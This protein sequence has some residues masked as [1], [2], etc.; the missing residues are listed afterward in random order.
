MKYFLIL[1]LASTCCL[2]GDEGAKIAINNRILTN[3]NG[4]PITLMDVTK[5]MDM[6]L[7]ARYADKFSELPFRLS[8]YRE[9][10]RSFLAEMIDH[11]LLLES[12]EELK[13]PV[14]NGDVR[15]ELETSFGPNILTN[16]EKAGL[17]FEEAFEMVKT[18]IITR[19]MLLWQVTSRIHAQITP[20]E[21]VQE[22]ENYSKAMKGRKLFSYQ[23]LSF[24]SPDA[25]IALE[26]ANAAKVLLD[27]KKLAP[28]DLKQ[29]M[30]Q[31]LQESAVTC[32]VSDLITQKK[33][34]MSPAILGS[35]SALSFGTYSAPA[36]QK[37]R[38]DSTSYVRIL[39]LKESKEITPL[40]FHDA[41]GDLR[42]ALLEKKYAKASDEYFANLRKHYQV[43]FE[44]I[45][46]E[47]PRDFVPYTIE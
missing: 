43:K 21:I 45:A 3:I 32:D 2:F 31:K 41:E 9:N 10:W 14:S 42:E 1:A 11:E 17:T 16:L 8:F 46:K 33:E 7:L 13:M 36:Q 29:E 37:S 23:I 26:V 24:R 19:R 34:E 4:K 40:S 6:M 20:E 18:D 12:A 30:A 22:Y 27:E 35:L 15:Q 38:T 39:F 47:L 44:D 28:S 5:K 25:A